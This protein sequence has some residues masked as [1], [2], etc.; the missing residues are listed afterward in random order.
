MLVI[1]IVELALCFS[2][3][4]FLLLHSDFTQ[5]EKQVHEDEEFARTLA[6]LEEEPQAKK[7]I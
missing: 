4:M 2:V 1:F 7:V 3:L 5:L 6:M